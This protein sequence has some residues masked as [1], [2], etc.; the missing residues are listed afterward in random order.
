MIHPKAK[1]PVKPGKFHSTVVGQAW[2]RHSH[3]QRENLEER[4]CVSKQVQNLAG[5]IP[6]DFKTGE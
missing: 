5:Q 6:F 2:D 3:S 4:D 1:I